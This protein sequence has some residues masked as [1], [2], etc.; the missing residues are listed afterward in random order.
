MKNIIF[1]LLISCTAAA[2][3]DS[4]ILP[5][6]DSIDSY[7]AKYAFE[8]YIPDSSLHALKPMAH[9][10]EGFERHGL[11][12]LGRQRI[13]LYNRKYWCKYSY[14]V[15]DKWRGQDYKIDSS[16]IKSITILKDRPGVWVSHW[17][18]EYLI[19]ITTK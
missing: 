3:Q 13:L 15:N 5:L 16:K 7:P 9:R 12:S 10:F 19:I 8:L 4:T 1:I 18:S 6:L 14:V 2:Q 17:G 11:D